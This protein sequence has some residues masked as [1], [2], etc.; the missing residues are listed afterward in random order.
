[1]IRFVGSTVTPTGTDV[2][3]VVITPAYTTLIY[4][5][6]SSHPAISNKTAT[7]VAGPSATTTTQFP[8]SVA[9]P[10]QLFFGL[11][12]RETTWSSIT[13]LTTPPNGNVNGT[14]YY[15]KNWLA[16]TLHLQAALTV[17]SPLTLPAS[18]LA[19]NILVGVVPSGYTPTVSAYFTS[20]YYAANL[21]KDDLGVSWVKHLTSTINTGG[22]ILINF[23]KPD[24][25]VTAYSVV[26]NT[27]IPLD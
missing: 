15:K 6:G 13:V 2:P 23:I 12:G 11:G 10:Y 1:M 7:L 25:A 5:D 19:A 17:N 9:K 4:N 27:I 16:N 26:F 3:L 24:S 20:Y 21:F 8:Y 22:Q 14:I 18:P